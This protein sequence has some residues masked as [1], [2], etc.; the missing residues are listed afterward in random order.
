MGSPQRGYHQRAQ[1]V[2]GIYLVVQE[3]HQVP[4]GAY[5]GGRLALDF[6]FEFPL[7]LAV[8]RIM[9]REFDAAI[10]NTRAGVNMYGMSWGCP[11][12]ASYTIHRG[13]GSSGAKVVRR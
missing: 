11:A 13:G 7:R 9:A 12:N 10:S 5:L 6:P 8:R 3:D 4:R 2:V 1:L